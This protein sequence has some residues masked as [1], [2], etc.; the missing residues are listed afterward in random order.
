MFANSRYEGVDRS[1][2]QAV[3]VVMMQALG[4]VLDQLILARDALLLC[5]VAWYLG[6]IAS[7]LQEV[8]IQPLGI[9]GQEHFHSL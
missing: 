2:V 4:R 7:P 9:Q 8:W 6:T 5:V 3:A 1:A